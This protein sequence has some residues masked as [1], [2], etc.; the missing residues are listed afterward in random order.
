MVLIVNEMKP[1][2]KIVRNLSQTWDSAKLVAGR[3]WG[4]DHFQ[5]CFHPCLSPK[6]VAR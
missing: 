4:C 5:A 3:L 1:S 6:V 2:L